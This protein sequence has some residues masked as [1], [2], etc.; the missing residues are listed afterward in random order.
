MIIFYHFFDNIVLSKLISF[1]IKICVCHFWIMS[2]SVTQ[3]A[4]FKNLQGGR[5]FSIVS[6][7]ANNFRYCNLSTVVAFNHNKL[8]NPLTMNSLSVTS[9]M[10]WPS[11]KMNCGD[12]RLQIATL[13][14][15]CWPQYG[16]SDKLVVNMLRFFIT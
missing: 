5:S 14:S 1:M 6:R 9:R 8:W 7:G 15:P 10:L 13:W 3:V 11:A 2:V 4:I 16:Y 12:Q